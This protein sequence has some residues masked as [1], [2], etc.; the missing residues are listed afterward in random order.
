M[1]FKDFLKEDEEL[2]TIPKSSKTTL[3]A[4][5]K[6]VLA[7]SPEYAKKMINGERIYRGQT[8]TSSFEIGYSHSFKRKSLNSKNFYTKF[9][10][11]SPAWKEFPSREHAYICAT[12]VE[13]AQG[14]GHTYL[15]VP[16][17]NAQI[18]I[19]PAH[20]IWI[21]FPRLNGIADI[22]S[23]NSL[24]YFL[25]EFYRVV[26]GGAAPEDL[27]SVMKTW[28][29]EILREGSIGHN[30]TGLRMSSHSC[31]EEARAY[32]NAMEKHG[33]K[34]FKELTEWMLDPKDNGFYHLEAKDIP[35]T[36]LPDNT[37]IW[38]EGDMLFVK[39]EVAN[40]FID[41]LKELIK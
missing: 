3:V 37:E 22:K 41:L 32:A 29:P 19:C 16:A 31:V 5:K 11:Q 24:N 13:L 40:D 28:T 26:E 38:I 21:S 30:K 8:T 33:F 7:H 36:G 20:D 23:I 18:G 14:Y 2:P 9:I 39:R 12:S 15:V 1:R 35:S 6:W 34:N 10:A 27:S 17:D 25:E 4:A